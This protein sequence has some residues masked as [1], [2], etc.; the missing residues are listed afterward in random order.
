MRVLFLILL[1]AS[2]G[3]LSAAGVFTVL[4]AVGLVIVLFIGF[5]FFSLLQQVWS[6]IRTVFDELMLW[7]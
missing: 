3:L 7:Q 2:F 5:L 4:T 6:F 1:G